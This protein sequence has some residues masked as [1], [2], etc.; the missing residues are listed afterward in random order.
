MYGTSPFE[1]FSLLW[2]K[3][4][5]RSIDRSVHKSR[6]IFNGKLLF[7]YFW[8]ELRTYS[9]RMQSEL[10][11]TNENNKIVHYFRSRLQ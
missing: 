5:K 9:L 1:S 6:G 11:E 8:P 4:K 3:K 7:G 2:K 10:F